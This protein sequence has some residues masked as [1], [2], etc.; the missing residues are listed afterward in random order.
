MNFLD[1]LI[2]KE[3]REVVRCSLNIKTKRKIPKKKCV[4][5]KKEIPETNHCVYSTRNNVTIRAVVKAVRRD[6]NNYRRDLVPTALR[7]L[8]VL[9]K[10]KKLNK[11][12][13]REKDK[14]KK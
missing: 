13:K 14:S 6:L 12:P 5:L 9:Y 3:K 10:F 1:I 11:H 8:Y 2:K 4:E 7:K